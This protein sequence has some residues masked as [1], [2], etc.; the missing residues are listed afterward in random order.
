MSSRR[1]DPWR[2]GRSRAFGVTRLPRGGMSTILHPQ[3]PR[4]PP[5]SC[6]SVGSLPLGHIA[7]ST[8]TAPPASN[9]ALL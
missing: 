4:R 1:M 8:R 7:Q 3:K 2:M 5:R 6:S 9:L